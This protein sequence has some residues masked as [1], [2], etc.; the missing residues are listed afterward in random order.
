M[1]LNSEILGQISNKYEGLTT[2]L[3]FD[4][5]RVWFY[6]TVSKLDF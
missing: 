1:Y 3:S 5:V 2:F 4:I 6:L